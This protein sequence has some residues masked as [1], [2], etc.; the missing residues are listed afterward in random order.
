MDSRKKRLYVLALTFPYVEKKLE[1]STSFLA[2]G[3][4]HMMEPFLQEQLIAK[5]SHAPLFSL[6]GH[7]IRVVLEL[8]QKGFFC[9]L[10]GK[11][12]EDAAANFYAT[13]LKRVDVNSELLKSAMPTSQVLTLVSPE[14]NKM[15]SA[16]LGASLELDALDL[17]PE[18]FNGLDVL[19]LDANSLLWGYLPLKAIQMA[20]KEGASIC[21]FLDSI[22]DRLPYRSQIV[23]L[24]N[25]FVD[26]FVAE[27]EELEPFL[28]ATKFQ[29]ETFLKKRSKS[30]LI[31]SNKEE[32]CTLCSNQERN[33][34]S[35]KENK[36]DPINGE[37]LWVS[38]LCELFRKESLKAGYLEELLNLSPLKFN[39]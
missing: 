23:T 1:V 27:K 33:E 14:S 26:I 19:F 11:V 17:K 22:S 24:L 37:D 36:L 28:N 16:Y 18:Y 32:R 39:L 38:P 25:D 30:A 29:M 13:C 6:G 3:V 2:Q 10:I 15:Q 34:I 5:S 7:L 20:K 9:E 4:P 35:L 21:F 31:F 12:G 8:A